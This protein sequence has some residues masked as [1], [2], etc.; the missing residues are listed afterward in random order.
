MGSITSENKGGGYSDPLRKNSITNPLF[1]AE[2]FP[3]YGRVDYN[4]VKCGAIQSSTLKLPVWKQ[5]SQALLYN[6][7]IHL[8]G[9]I[10]YCIQC[11]QILCGHFGDNSDTGQVTKEHSTIST[12]PNH[13]FQNCTVMHSFSFYC[14]LLYHTACNSLNYSAYTSCTLK[15][16]IYHFTLVYIVSLINDIVV[17]FH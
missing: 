3:K 6:T 2:C 16:T 7:F 11:L 1:L 10:L 8:M 17:A 15:Y 9:L 12:P 4:A 5:R 14:F 13:S